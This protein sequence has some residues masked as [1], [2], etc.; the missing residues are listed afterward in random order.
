MSHALAIRGEQVADSITVLNCGKRILFRE[1]VMTRGGTQGGDK[2]DVADLSSSHGKDSI[3]RPGWRHLP[4]G[5]STSRPVILTWH[6]IRLLHRLE[7]DSPRETRPWISSAQDRRRRRKEI[8]SG[9]RAPCASI[10]RF[11]PLL[12]HAWPQGRSPSNPVLAPR[13]TPIRW[14][15]R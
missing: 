14:V 5:R 2:D 9:S 12:P 11:K 13:G 8:R 3:S 1:F 6:A 7:N 15:R 4:Q 10:R